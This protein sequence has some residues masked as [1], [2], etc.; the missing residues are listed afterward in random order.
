MEGTIVN[1][2]AALF[3]IAPFKEQEEEEE[4][5]QINERSFTTS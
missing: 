4:K 2:V 3:I 5:R 1:N